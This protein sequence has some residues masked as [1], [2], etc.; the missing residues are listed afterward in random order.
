MNKNIRIAKEL[1]K[2]AKYIVSNNFFNKQNIIDPKLYKMKTKNGIKNYISHSID[3]LIK[4]HFKD[5]NWSNVKKVFDAI[6]NLGVNLNWYVE[7]GGYSHDLSSKTYKFDISFIN[8]QG[9]EFQFNGQ[10]IC[11]FC[12]TVEDPMSTYD[13]IFQIF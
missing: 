2:L 9:K 11:C 1:I 7:N 13:M 4:G 12:G 10:L 5:E 6:S 8:F 3:K